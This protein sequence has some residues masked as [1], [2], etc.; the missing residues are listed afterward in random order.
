MIWRDRFLCG[1]CFVLMVGARAY[2]GPVNPPFFPTFASGAPSAGAPKSQLYFDTDTTPLGAYVWQ[3]SA[4]VW[5]PYGGGGGA[6][7]GSAGDILYSST[8]S[9]CIGASLQWNGAQLVWASNG[10]LDD[11]GDIITSGGFNLTVGAGGN[12]SFATGARLSTTNGTLNVSSANGVLNLTADT[13]LNLNAATVALNGLAFGVFATADHASATAALD[14]FSPSLQGLVPA[15]PGGTTTFLRADGTWAAASGSTVTWPANGS[16]VVSN[17]TNSPA[18]IAEIDGKVLVGAGGAWLAGNIPIASV[19]GGLCITTNFSLQYDNSGVAGC[20]PASVNSGVFN[21]TGTQLQIQGVS[22]LDMQNF[23]GGNGSNIGVGY[24]AMSGA[25][26]TTGTG[27]VSFGWNAGTGVSIGSSGNTLIGSGAGASVG[28][29][30]D[31]NF[32]T[33]LGEGVLCGS[34]CGGPNDSCI[35]PS[36]SF[37]ILIGV[38]ANCALSADNVNNEFDVCAASGSTPLMRG[39]LDASKLTL[40]V[41]GTLS[42][43]GYTVATLPA[44]APQAVIGARAYVT[45]ALACT[46]LGALTGGGSTFCPVEYNGSA[47]IAG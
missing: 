1:V 33:V 17:T 4:S 3:P 15:S 41:N 18:G 22:L 39:S 25:N 46:F 40:Q 8:G 26:L 16:V 24:Q 5:Q 12:I 34:L 14:L 32:L 9:N 20:A 21:F 29:L 42:T 23:S 43:A 10:R 6:C 28:G 36:C 37:D 31:T 47:W 45:D 7:A 38:G 30:G 35:S 11:P 2:S 44:A 27:N 13:D 19:S